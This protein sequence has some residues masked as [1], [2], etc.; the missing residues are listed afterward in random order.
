MTDLAER[1]C[2]KTPQQ[3]EKLGGIESTSYCLVSTKGVKVIKLRASSEGYLDV[4][5]GP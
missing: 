5:D 4:V 3:C 1:Y 2:V